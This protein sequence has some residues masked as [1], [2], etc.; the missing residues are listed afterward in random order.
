[1]A[2]LVPPTPIQLLPDSVA[3]RIA[4]GEVIDRPA[5]AVK[6]L[7]ENAIDAGATE[8]H[9]EAR[10]GGLRL[11]RVSDNGC[12]I[13]ADQIEL[14]FRRHA[15][16]KLRSLDDL[17]RLE[18][19]GFRGEALASIAAVAEVSVTSAAEGETGVCCSFYAGRLLE[20]A[21]AGRTRGTTIVV[22]DLFSRMPARLKFLR[23]AR[24]EAIQIGATLRRFALARPDLRLTLV[25]D[26]HRVFESLGGGFDE[27]LIA[28]YGAELA[29]TLLPLDPVEVAGTRITGV[30][31]APSVARATRSQMPVFVNG[32]YVR[33]AALLSAAEAG[34]RT[35]LPRGRHPAGAIFLAVPPADLDANVHPGKL[36]VRLA[37]EAAV[38]RALTDAVSG[39]Y[40]RNPRSVR[41]RATLALEGEQ[42][43]IPGLRRRIG[44]G[45]VTWSGW[46]DGRDL[47][48]GGTLPALRLLGQAQ[49]AVLIAEGSG[50]LYLVDQHRAHERVIYE[51]LTAPGS[52]GGQALIEPVLLE[53]Y[54]PAAEQLNARLPALESLGF[55]C[56]PFGAGG[57]LVRATPAVEALDLQRDA[58]IESLT[59]AA[60]GQ[61]AWQ[62][63]FLASLA[64]RSAIR[65]GRPLGAEEARDLLTRLGA[66]QSPALCPHGSPI[67]LQ[68]D[69][70]FLTR[71]FNWG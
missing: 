38:A 3:G 37:E 53:L 5:A 6:E 22:Q 2:T 23:G 67:I 66:T 44:E 48:A 54:G 68:L 62:E 63:R 64:C 18:T 45:R 57:F 16:S 50:A 69:E 58:L 20:R 25:L 29:A 43:R 33:S 10:G 11:I 12:G 60:A 17:E 4:A 70:S 32:R 65:K 41:S 13:P 52:A 19:F 28:V 14:A 55:V 61:A 21:P 24:A 59:E 7:V 31:S 30:L 35:A 34:Y 71:Q 40:A 26:G 42:P 46:G 51:R 56:E 9:V 8:I 39:V 1:M 27:A 36:D 49:N 47:P 15:T